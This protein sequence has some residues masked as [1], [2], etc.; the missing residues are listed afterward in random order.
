[1][2]LLAVISLVENLLKVRLD[3]YKLCALSRRPHVEQVEDAGNWRY[4]P[5]DF[6]DKH[7]AS[8]VISHYNQIDNYQ[9]IALTNYIIT[10]ISVSTWNHRL[11][12]Y[13][14]LCIHL[15]MCLELFDFFPFLAVRLLDGGDWLDA[16]SGHLHEHGDLHD[17]RI[18][19][20]RV[21]HSCE[22]HS[23]PRL[24]PGKLLF[25]PTDSLLWYV[26]RFLHFLNL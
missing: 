16:V 12:L 11:K 6:W 22:S 19:L 13:Y 18:E 1:M 4:P 20:Q 10:E 25:L 21:F 2:P 15:L 5:N 17:S 9:F 24:Q 23:F 26:T 8:I 3:A 7:L 14:L